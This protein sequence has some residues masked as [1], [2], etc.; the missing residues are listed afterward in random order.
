[1]IG[2]ATATAS[3]SSGLLYAS[4][5]YALMGIVGIILS[6]FPLGL[7]G[8]WMLPKRVFAAGIRG[9]PELIIN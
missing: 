2:L 9:E 5:S 7:T 1:M 3:L 4:T 6:L 8:W